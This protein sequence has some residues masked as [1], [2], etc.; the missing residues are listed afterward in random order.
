MSRAR[1]ISSRCLRSLTQDQ[2]MRRSMDVL[3]NGLRFRQ[4]SIP[5]LL[6]PRMLRALQYAPR[7]RRWLLHHPRER[8]RCRALPDPPA[9]SRR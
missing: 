3:G 2:I 6:A 8:R 1:E 7:F 5:H 9:A 4:C